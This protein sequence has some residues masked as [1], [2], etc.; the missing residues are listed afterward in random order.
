MTS[1]TTSLML[2][3]RLMMPR[4]F[5]ECCYYGNLITAP[6]MMHINNFIINVRRG[7]HEIVEQV[8][9]YVIHMPSKKGISSNKNVL[10]MIF[11]TFL[12]FDRVFVSARSAI[13]AMI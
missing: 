12:T 1:L 10:H 3:L 7:G 8:T 2:L 5:C 9:T 4:V 13:I 6:V 11:L